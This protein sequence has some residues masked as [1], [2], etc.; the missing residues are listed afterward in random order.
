[1]GGRD[2]VD[3]RQGDAEWGGEVA[4][5]LAWPVLSFLKCSAVPDSIWVR[6][7]VFLFFFFSPFFF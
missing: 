2:A 6:N 5:A 3:A 1:M 7:T 4:S